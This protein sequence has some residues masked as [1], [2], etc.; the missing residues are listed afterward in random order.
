LETNADVIAWREWVEEARA[1]KEI[2]ASRAAAIRHG[3]RV[4][5]ELRTGKEW[6][7]SRSPFNA[8]WLARMQRAYGK[9]LAA[10]EAPPDQT[11]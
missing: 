2:T 3:L 11:K 1:R 4:I 7:P 5:E 9:L 6:R 10:Q 8:R